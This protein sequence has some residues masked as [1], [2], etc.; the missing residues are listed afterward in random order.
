MFESCSRSL[1]CANV[2][3]YIP[4][5]PR[6]R[7][8]AL[9][10]PFFS[11]SHRE[12]PPWTPAALPSPLFARR[13]IAVSGAIPSPFSSAL[14]SHFHSHPHVTQDS[15][16]CVEA[17]P[18]G[19]S[20]GVG[21]RWRQDED[22]VPVSRAPRG[23]V[24]RSAAKGALSA[25][26][27]PEEADGPPPPF[28]SF[29]LCLLSSARS[30]RR[31]Q[32]VIPGSLSRASAWPPWRAA[33]PWGARQWCAVSRPRGTVARGTVGHSGALDMPSAAGRH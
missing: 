28:F 29:C 20:L 18:R 17:R 31:A 16:S 14:L 2:V 23:G 7:R 12:L 26:C 15:S 13:W 4:P 6:V 3:F 11:S 27:L 22:D 8:G 5:A 32:A 25:T 9:L 21:W 33:R 10:P 30:Q 24:E 19:R 1:C